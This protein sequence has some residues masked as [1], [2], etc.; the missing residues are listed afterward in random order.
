MNTLTL[1]H[2]EQNNRY[3]EIILRNLSNADL[4][5]IFENL[6]P[7]LLDMGIIPTQNLGLM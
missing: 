2:S 3:D 4:K 6:L 5:K 1:M 7:K